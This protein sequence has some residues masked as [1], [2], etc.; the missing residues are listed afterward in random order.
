MD[1]R[2][3]AA[4]KTTKGKGQKGGKCLNAVRRDMEVIGVRIE[5]EENRVR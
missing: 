2:D 1:V 4:Q 5:S 3:A